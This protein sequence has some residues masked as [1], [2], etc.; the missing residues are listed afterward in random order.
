VLGVFGGGGVDPYGAKV[1]IKTAT[2]NQYQVIGSQSATHSQSLLNI[3]H[4]G[5]AQ[6]DSI[7]SVIV[8][9]RDGSSELLN[10]QPADQLISIGNLNN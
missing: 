6:A 7:S 4:F 10:K 2:A 1:Q 5:L 3:V 9:W 8:T